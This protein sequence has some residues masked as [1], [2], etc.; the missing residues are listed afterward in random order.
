MGICN[1]TLFKWWCHLH[2]WRNNSQRQFEHRKFD[3]NLRKSSSQKLLNRILRYCTQID[4]DYVLLTFVQMV[5]PPTL[6]TN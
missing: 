6:T 3:A 4:L 5:A 1:Q 2:Y